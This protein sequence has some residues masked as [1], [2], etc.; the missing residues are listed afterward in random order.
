MN[1]AQTVRG[2]RAA[3]AGLPGTVKAGRGQ[4]GTGHDRQLEATI[5]RLPQAAFFTVLPTALL[6]ACCNAATVR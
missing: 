5:V 2:E 6:S 1:F 3:V 4:T